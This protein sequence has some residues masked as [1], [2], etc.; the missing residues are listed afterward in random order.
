MGGIKQ[1]QGDAPQQPRA[2]N[3]VDPPQEEVSS[4]LYVCL[5]WFVLVCFYLL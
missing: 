5:F 4:S 1:E 3:S 2:S